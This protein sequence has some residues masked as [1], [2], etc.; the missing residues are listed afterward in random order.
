MESSCCSWTEGRRIRQSRR[1]LWSI[2]VKVLGRVDRSHA[3]FRTYLEVDHC[4]DDQVDDGLSELV[5]GQTRRSQLS[6]PDG[7]IERHC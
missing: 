7:G 2:E 5:H 1:S 3:V 6:F 4:D